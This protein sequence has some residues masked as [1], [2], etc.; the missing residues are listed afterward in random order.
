[1]TQAHCL[2]TSCNPPPGHHSCVRS[3]FSFED[4]VPSYQLL[5]LLGKEFLHA[6]CHIAL[7]VVLGLMVL[8]ILESEFGDLCLAVRTFLPA[9]LRAFVS[10]DVYIFGREKFA[11]FSEDILKELHGLFLSDAENVVGDTPVTPYFVGTACTSELRISCKRSKHM[12]RKVN[13]R[14]YSNALCSCI[15]QDLLYL[16]L[17]EIAAFSVACMVI[18]IALEDVADDGLVSDGSHF[19]KAWVF[20]DLKSPALVVGEVP[21]EGIE[22]VDFHDVEIFLDLVHVEE[23]T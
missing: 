21:V 11:Y 18:F 8:I 5:A 10:T 20:L 19:C 6:C 17:S 3:D 13:L 12:A 15:F 2:K 22:L 1:M 7:K 9:Y 16:V 4:L 14:N 23:V